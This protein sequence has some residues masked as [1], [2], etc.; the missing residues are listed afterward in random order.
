[1]DHDVQ[2]Q[3]AVEGCCILFY[4]LDLRLNLLANRSQYIRSPEGALACTTKVRARPC[5]SAQA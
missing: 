1:M 2:V 4:V 5:V 3:L